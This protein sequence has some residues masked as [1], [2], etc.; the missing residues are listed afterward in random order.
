M[1]RDIIN[2]QA[3][4]AVAVSYRRWCFTRGSNCKGV[5][6]KVLVFWIGGRL[7][8]VIAHE[9]STVYIN[10]YLNETAPCANGSLIKILYSTVLYL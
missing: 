8:E 2:R 1:A 6:G 7:W 3:Q 10:Q 9:D 5:I 4:K